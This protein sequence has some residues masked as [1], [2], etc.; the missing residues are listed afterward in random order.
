METRKRSGIVPGILL[1][2]V[3]IVLLAF[4]LIPGL[5]VWFNAA[6]AWPLLVIGVGI[7]LAVIGLAVREP[8]MAVPAT[9]VTGI[10]LLLLYQNTTGDWDSWA[11]AWSLIPG[12]VGLGIILAALLGSHKSQ[13]Y[14]AGGILLFIS[15]VLF[16][17]FGS[18]LGPFDVL[19]QL[20]P[21]AVI[22]LG[23]I[24]LFTS[25]RRK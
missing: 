17:V 14:Q 19:G 13:D 15:A 4:Q 16:M 10:G 6:G 5:Q 12:F 11:Y 23:V 20:W 21:L 25:L 7:L 18:F 8:G 3:G 24:L 1:V 22:L 9:I 2:L